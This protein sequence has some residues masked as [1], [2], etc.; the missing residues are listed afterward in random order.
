[1]SKVLRKP[2]IAFFGASF[3]FVAGAPPNQLPIPQ[4]DMM[5]YALVLIDSV[6]IVSRLLESLN[7]KV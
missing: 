2:S 4:P 6:G 7:S 1:M 3:F 5:S